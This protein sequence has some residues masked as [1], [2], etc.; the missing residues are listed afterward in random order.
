MI[1]NSVG[2]RPGREA[3]GRARLPGWSLRPLRPLF[4]LRPSGPRNL[5]RAEALKSLV[6]SVPGL[7]FTEVTLFF[8]SCSEPTE[9][10]GGLRAA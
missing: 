6:T 4:A 9:P 5:E 10:F 3:L 7:T 8:C 2:F 1:W